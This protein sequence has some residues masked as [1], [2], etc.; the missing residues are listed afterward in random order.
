MEALDV[1]EN[2]RDTVGQGATDLSDAYSL[3]FL[4][5][6]FVILCLILKALRS[7]KG[8]LLVSTC[9]FL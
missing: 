1:S 4:D 5:L 7:F 2:I 3:G 8:L 9:L 6:C